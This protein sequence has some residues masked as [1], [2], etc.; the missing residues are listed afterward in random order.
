MKHRKL[1]VIAFH[2]PPDNTSTGVLRT[3]KFTQY[4][5]KFGWCSDIVSVDESI[6]TNTDY[7]LN[8]QVPTTTRIYR[9][10][11][12][13]IKKMFS[14]KGIYPGILAIPDRYWP[15]I[16]SAAKQGKQ[17]L[18]SNDYSVIYATYP[19]PSA[20]IVGWIL[21]R[22]TGIPLVVDF[23]DPWVEESMPWINRFIEGFL[24]RNIILH[25][26]RVI[27]NTPA[28]RKSFLKR[29]PNIADHKFV[30]ITNG[31]DE[32]D[33]LNLTPKSIDKFEI[34]YPG[35]IDTEN[36][37]PEPLLSAISIC[38]SK[39]WLSHNDLQITFLGCGPLFSALGLSAQPGGG[40]R[41]K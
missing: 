11:A 3:L 7:N 35:I 15:W 2:Y 14:I 40:C 32:K 21:K 26:D 33:F 1:L 8:K 37:D 16:Y 5:E 38:L 29:Y 24:E 27:C 28:M 19:H 17:L 18:D 9:T 22:K 12:F 6:Y 41:S 34:L 4:L 30:T 20:L 36:R 23:R 13:D 25:A 10:K 39:G 31:Y